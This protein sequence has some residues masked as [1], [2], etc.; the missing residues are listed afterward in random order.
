MISQLSVEL[1]T[2]ASTI[3][4]LNNLSNAQGMPCQHV[5]FRILSTAGVAGFDLYEIYDQSPMADVP[6]APRRTGENS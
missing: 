6:S 4:L 2:F 3:A 1:S 5:E